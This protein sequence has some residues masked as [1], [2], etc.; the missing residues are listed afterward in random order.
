M[1]EK[2]LFTLAFIKQGSKILMINRNKQPW[3]GM[4]NGVGGKLKKEEDPLT[5][6]IREVKEETGL[7]FLKSD[8]KYRG[9]VTWNGLSNHLKNG[10]NQ[11][12][13][14]LYLI[15]LPKDVNFKTPIKTKEG[16]LDWKNIDFLIDK[17]NLGIPYNIPY[18][19]N[20]VINSNL[21]YQYDCL[22]D[23]NYLLKVN[24]KELK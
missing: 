5:A 13:L 6:I 16:I 1:K 20:N 12:G 10:F 15:N 11:N 3:Q 8:V 4:W 7:S 2:Y 22:F 17:D 14:Y 23:G 9:V 24:I 21:L 19:I 18:F